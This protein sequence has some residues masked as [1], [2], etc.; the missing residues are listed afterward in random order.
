[1]CRKRDITGSAPSFVLYTAPLAT[2]ILFVSQGQFCELFT[3]KWKYQRFYNFQESI[4][5]AEY[6][7]VDRS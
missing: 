5:N 3:K 1:M 7:T 6:T 4:E 2:E